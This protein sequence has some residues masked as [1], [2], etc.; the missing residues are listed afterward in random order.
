M[1]NRTLHRRLVVIEAEFDQAA[2]AIERERKS[3]AE[4]KLSIDEAERFYKWFKD[5]CS[6]DSHSED[7][8]KLTPNEAMARYLREVGRTTP[9]H[10]R[11][12]QPR[13]R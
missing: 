11:W 7:W 3:L 1:R 12:M 2:N 8:T 10:R 4:S 5:S 6:G 13:R 9:H